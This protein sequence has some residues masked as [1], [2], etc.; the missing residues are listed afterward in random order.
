MDHTPNVNVT[1]TEAEKDA[2]ISVADNFKYHILRA[3]EELRDA[4]STL[5]DIGDRIIEESKSSE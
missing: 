4:V 1:L 2:L 5:R 3:F